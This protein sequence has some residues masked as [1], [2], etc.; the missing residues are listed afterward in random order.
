M[1]AAL[2]SDDFW[3]LIAPLL[4]PT[5]IQA[6]GRTSAHTRSSLPPRGCICPSNRHPLGNAPQGTGLRFWN[7]LL[8]ASA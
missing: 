1:V 3:N 8:E 5:R 6:E 4:P 7:D 2:I